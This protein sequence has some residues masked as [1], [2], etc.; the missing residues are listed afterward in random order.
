MDIFVRGPWQRESPIHTIGTGDSFTFHA[1]GFTFSCH[2][3]YGLIRDS[4][5][6]LGGCILRDDNEPKIEKDG[7]AWATIQPAQRMEVADPGSPANGGTKTYTE[8]ELCF[9]VWQV[10]YS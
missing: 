8:E 6:N 4:K 3:L 7:T 1:T 10:E 2:G 9:V 5:G